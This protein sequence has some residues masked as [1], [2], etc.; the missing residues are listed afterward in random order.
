[1]D[2]P[3]RGVLLWSVLWFYIPPSGDGVTS[4][5][6]REKHMLVGGPKYL[7]YHANQPHA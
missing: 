4:V 7:V 2:T 1:M 5:L 3:N 6:T